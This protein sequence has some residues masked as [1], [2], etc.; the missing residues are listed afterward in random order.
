MADRMAGRIRCIACAGW[1][2]LAVLVTLLPGC[3][4]GRA[5][6]RSLLLVSV[7]TLRADH[8][9]CY[10]YERQTSPRLDA[11]AAEGRRFE[12]VWSVMPTTLPSHAALFTSLYPRQTGARSNGM[13]VV[14]GVLTLAERLKQ[15][16]FS[17]GAFVSSVPLHPDF[18]LDQGFDRYD[19]PPGEERPGDAT[20]ARAVEWLREHAGGPFFCFVH[21]FDPHTWY[22]APRAQRELFDVPA[23]RLPPV[24]DFGGTPEVFDAQVRRDSIAAYDA[25]IRFADEQLGILLDELGALGVDGETLVVFVSDHGETLDELIDAYGYAFD[26]GE[27]LHRRELRVPLVLRVPEGLPG[28][29]PGVHPEQVSTLDL[30]PTLLELLDVPAAQPL[31]GRS[32][33]P[34]LEGRA[35]P[36]RPVFA[37]RRLLT[38]GERVSPPSRFL[39]GEELSVA[40]A[41]WHLVRCEGRPLELFDLAADPAQTRNVA[42]SQPDAVAR[43]QGL[44]DGWLGAYREARSAGE[45]PVDPAL[46]EALRSL[47]YAADDPR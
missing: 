39:V 7:D 37:E 27:F 23:G 31:V 30:L 47:G 11:L 8:L 38:R 43:L 28:A 35:L 29:G 18:G 4:R 13:R 3:G 40:T 14:P 1:A 34:L 6:A 24:F 42:G 41:R 21:L 25:E 12:N 5:E 20:R 2:L 22:T 33:V 17:T 32:Q 9:S 46:L 10:G 26:H 19:F 36:A 16:G 45:S 44:L 15:R